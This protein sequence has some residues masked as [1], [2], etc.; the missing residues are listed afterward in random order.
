MEVIRNTSTYEQIVA[1]NLF[2]LVYFSGQ[3]CSVCQALK[4][5]IE[6]LV[7]DNFSDIVLVEIPTEQLPDLAARLSVFTIPV[8]LFFVEGKEYI[9][10]VRFI[11]TS[12]LKTKIE[13]ILSLYK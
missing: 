9:R 11:D 3:N 2:V 12:V 8:I 5:K 1:S 4:P 6:K 13:K 10:E 7:A